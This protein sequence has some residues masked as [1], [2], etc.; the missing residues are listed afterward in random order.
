MA[1][2]KI[3]IIDDHPAMCHGLAQLIGN[4]G[5]LEVCGQAGDREAA[6]SAIRR[7]PPDFVIL[8]IALKEPSQSGLDLI[9]EI[10]AHAGDIPILIYSM[11]DELIYA[12]RA[13]RTGARGYLMKQAPVR[14]IIQAIRR[15]LDEGIYVSDA[16]AR[17][18]LMAQVGSGGEQQGCTTPEACLS[19]REFEVFRLIGR[20]LQP[21]EIAQQLCLSVK[22]VETHRMNIRKKLALRDASNLTRFAVDWVH[23]KE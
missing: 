12:A 9:P 1:P 10:N 5:D 19:E 7:N 21:R 16:M 18:L 8:D 6:L 4:E 17:R 3:L 2:V 20:G 11:H 23:Q 15:I 14:E 13:L 22:T